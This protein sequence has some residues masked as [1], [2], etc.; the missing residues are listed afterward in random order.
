MFK[1]APG[2]LSA[3]V[4]VSLFLISRRVV[5]HK[6]VRTSVLGTL[7]AMTLES[8]RHRSP[9]LVHEAVKPE[10]LPF[11]PADFNL[12]A[13]ALAYRQGGPRGSVL[14]WTTAATA[15]QT[16]LQVTLLA[17]CGSCRWFCGDCDKCADFESYF[18][19]LD[20]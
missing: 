10:W 17:N 9:F 14:L 15:I 19:C 3:P 2:E 20:N 4:R 13:A 18:S 5:T 11:P 7:E 12:C 8:F 1:T 16:L 6:W